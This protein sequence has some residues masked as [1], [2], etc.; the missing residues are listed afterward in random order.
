M[1]EMDAR[2]KQKYLVNYVLSL[3]IILKEM[4]GVNGTS[5]NRAAVDE[6]EQKLSELLEAPA[7]TRA[8]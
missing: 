1:D 3:R 6:I 4:S 5:E 2:K 7:P 8:G